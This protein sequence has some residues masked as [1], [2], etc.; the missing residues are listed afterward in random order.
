MTDN[1]L[2]EWKPWKVRADQ[3]ELLK[4][5]D[6]TTLETFYFDN[7]KILEN[8]AINYYYSR[9]QSKHLYTVE[10][11]LQDAYLDL[12]ADVDFSSPSYFLTSLRSSMYYS[13][14]GGRWNKDVYNAFANTESRNGFFSTY[15]ILDE[16][17]SEDS[18]RTLADV[19]PGG[20]SPYIELM[21]ERERCRQDRLEADLEPILRRIFT[22]R[23]YE[24]WSKGW[25]I[26]NLRAVIRRHAAELIE[27]LR[28]HGTPAHKLQ[29]NVATEEDDR[30]MI[31]ERKARIAW[32]EEHLEE[33][34]I[35]KRREVLHRIKLRERRRRKAEEKKARQNAQ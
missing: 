23:Q 14:F 30:A 28:K 15:T 19:I 2:P 26:I 32:E 9:G 17:I 25:N 12:F 7:L 20:L 33:L 22:P 18:G 21:N 5:K 24:Q 11:M 29:G 16:P 13:A 8:F 31:A 27:F 34:S 10:D 4:A 6:R 3:V 35:E 1:Y